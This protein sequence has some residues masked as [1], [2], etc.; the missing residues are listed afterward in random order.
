MVSMISNVDPPASLIDIY[1]GFPAVYH[2]KVNNM[3]NSQRFGTGLFTDQWNMVA[4]KVGV[5]QNRAIY[6]YITYIPLYIPG[7][8]GLTK[9]NEQKGRPTGQ[10]SFLALHCC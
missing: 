10:P 9:E 3:S 1:Q 8:T 6:Y 4:L 5:G 7:L 2:C